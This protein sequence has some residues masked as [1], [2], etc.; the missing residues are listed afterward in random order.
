MHTSTAADSFLMLADA[1]AVL[2]TTATLLR[3]AARARRFDTGA[4][5]S[6]ADWTRLAVAQGLVAA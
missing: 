2:G 5:Y 3:K 4:Q 6:L 1:A